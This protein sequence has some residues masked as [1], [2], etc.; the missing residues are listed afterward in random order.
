[1]LGKIKTIV[2]RHLGQNTGNSL[3]TSVSAKPSLKEAV[4]QAV[5]VT[6]KLFGEREWQCPCGHKF[7][8]SGEWVATLP[9]YCEVPSCPNPKFYV[10]GPGRALL[11]ANPSGVR[12]GEVKKEHRLPSSSSSSS[13]ARGV[14]S[15]FK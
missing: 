8:A 2:S 15:R 6:Q 3:I 7:R 4:N 5:Q 1:M 14:A 12:L 10:D 13:P 9:I 11:E